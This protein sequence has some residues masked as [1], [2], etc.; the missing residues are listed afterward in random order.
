MNQVPMPATGIFGLAS[1]L[2]PDIT[3]KVMDDEATRWGSVYD[4][5]N[6]NRYPEKEGT[7]LKIAVETQKLNW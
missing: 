2:H 6:T 4:I 7:E 5:R 1:D 3:S